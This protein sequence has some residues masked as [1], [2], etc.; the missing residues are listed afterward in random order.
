M[1]YY[2]VEDNVK[3]KCGGIGSVENGDY[4]IRAVR[5]NAHSD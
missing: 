1:A 4:F 2:M 3:M 5:T